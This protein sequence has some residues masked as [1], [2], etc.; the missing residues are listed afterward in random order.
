MEIAINC[1]IGFLGIVFLTIFNAKEY[2]IQKDKT[3]SFITHWNDNWRRWAWALSMVIAIAVITGVEPK[4][5][6]GMKTFT[7]LDIGGERAAFFTIGL[8][9]ISMIKKKKGNGMVQPPDPL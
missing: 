6:D 2:I 1:L 8:A 7:G 5:A 9:L 3:F 4:T